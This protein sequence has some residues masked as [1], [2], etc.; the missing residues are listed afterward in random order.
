MSFPHWQTFKEALFHSILEWYQL[1]GNTQREI[2]VSSQKI[3]H[4]SIWYKS[5]LLHIATLAIEINSFI[6]RFILCCEMAP[7]HM[8]SHVVLTSFTE[9]RVSW[10]N[11]RWGTTP[12]LDLPSPW[13]LRKPLLSP[14]QKTT[15]SPHRQNDINYFITI[16][17]RK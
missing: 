8:S 6:Y 17:S 9:T 15:V 14:F 11:M 10:T 13:N 4:P 2:Q 3:P 1:K 16:V 7:N 12:S 5:E